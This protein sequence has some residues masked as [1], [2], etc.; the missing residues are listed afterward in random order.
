MY[1][2]ERELV[3]DFKLIQVQ[4][5]SEDQQRNISSEK[6]HFHQKSKGQLNRVSAKVDI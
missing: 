3:K 6:R 4:K 1:R 2:S 5:Q